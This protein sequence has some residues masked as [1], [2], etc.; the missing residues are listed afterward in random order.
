MGLGWILLL[1]VVALIA[2]LAASS[3]YFSWLM[4]KLLF[5]KLSDM[6]YIRTYSMPPD[7]WQRKYLERARKRGSIDPEEQKKQTLKNLKKLEKIIK[8]AETTV[9]MENESFRREVLLVL[10]LVKREWQDSIDNPQ[11]YPYMQ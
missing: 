1:T 4:Q 9:Y 6:E 3:W 11:I 7:R 5:E 2:I 10:K 8:F